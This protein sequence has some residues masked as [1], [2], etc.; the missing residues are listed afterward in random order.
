M[1][2]LPKLALSIRQPW[3]W[4]I[5]NLGK[6]IE[7]RDWYTKFR[8]PVCIHASKGMTRDEYEGCLATVHTISRT[9]P[10]TPGGAFPALKELARGAIVGTAEITACVD[11]STSPWFFGR[12]GFVLHN[13][14]PVDFIPVN[15]ALGFFDWRRNLEGAN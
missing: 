1:S 12:Y 14:K 15:G 9:H 5:I 8:G 10:F 4:C 2:D 11:R 7:N 6:D 13:V 3:A